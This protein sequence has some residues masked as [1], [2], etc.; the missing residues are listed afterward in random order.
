M[1]KGIEAESARMQ[2]SA[3]LSES[4]QVDAPATGDAQKPKTIS[5][6]G[7]VIL[8]IFALALP[9]MSGLQNILGLLIIGF[10]LYQAW[11]MNIK[12]KLNFQGPFEIKSSGP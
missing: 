4:G 2:T 8:F 12:T 5:P 9:F 3:S 7:Y 1:V 6:I 10:G 11:Q